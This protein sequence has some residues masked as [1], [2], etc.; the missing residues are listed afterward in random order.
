MSLLPIN[1][2]D[3]VDV[4]ELF[5]SLMISIL[6]LLRI[7][8]CFFLPSSFLDP[9]F[10]LH[11]FSIKKGFFFFFFF[12]WK[13]FYEKFD[14]INILQYWD[15]FKWTREAKESRFDEISQYMYWMFE[16]KFCRSKRNDTSQNIQTWS[17]F[18]FQ[19]RLLIHHYKYI[20]MRTSTLSHCEQLSL[21]L[22][23]IIHVR[24]KWMNGAN[25]RV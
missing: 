9:Q 5:W 21:S 22:A 4:E 25:S 20:L 14:C 23:S 12:L 3:T 10:F 7:S 6:F 2:E 19:I 13:M 15:K 16:Y 11:N 1:I 18:Q 8:L 24:Q 17:F